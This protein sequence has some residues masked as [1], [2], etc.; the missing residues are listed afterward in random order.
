MTGGKIIPFSPSRTAGSPGANLGRSAEPGK[1]RAAKPAPSCG[2]IK[3]ST[4]VAITASMSIALFLAIVLSGGGPAGKAATGFR[5]TDPLRASFGYCDGPVR[6]NC[7]VDGDTFW[8]GGR[9]I[10]IAD[11]NTPEISNPG[12]GSEKRLGER[13]KVRLHGLL[14][15]GNFSLQPV[16]RDQ[17]KYG[18]DLRIVTRS[19][20]SLGDILVAE[21]LAERWQGTRKNWC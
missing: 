20:Q 10:R 15:Q 13:A 21:G 11:I 7:I 3:N 19:G 2:R 16:G 14:N 18:R 17:D 5:G 9:K 12:C 8:H 6:I 4:L 1:R